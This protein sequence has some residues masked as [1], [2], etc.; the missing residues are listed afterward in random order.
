MAGRL[1]P[2][3]RRPAIYST[4]G[5]AIPFQYL[6]LPVNDA[7]TIAAYRG[8]GGIGP[9]RPQ[10]RSAA[11]GAAARRQEGGHGGSLTTASPGADSAGGLAALRAEEAAGAGPGRGRC[12]EG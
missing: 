5:H 12:H 10:P 2:C 11:A 4:G 6:T 3:V 9:R 8:S 7:L 1:Y